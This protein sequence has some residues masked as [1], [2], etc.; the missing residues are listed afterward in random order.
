LAFVSIEV[1]DEAG[2]IVPDACPELHFSTE[3]AGE[4]VAADNG[5]STDW[6]PFHSPSRKAFNGLALAILKGNPGQSGK[7]TIQITAEGLTPATVSIEVD[8]SR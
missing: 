4:F 8:P 7:L 5:D 1:L 2:R 6:T 3:G